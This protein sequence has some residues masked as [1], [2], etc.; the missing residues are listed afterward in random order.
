MP[1]WRERKKLLEEYGRAVIFRVKSFMG[2][3]A[4][5]RRVKRACL[6]PSLRGGRR[7]SPQTPHPFK[8]D[9]CFAL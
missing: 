5:G 6:G 2:G 9:A 1:D 8:P 7:P 3:G 4:F